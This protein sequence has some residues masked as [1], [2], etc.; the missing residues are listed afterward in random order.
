MPKDKLA[1]WFE[2]YAAALELNVWPSTTLKSSSWDD[3]KRQWTVTL[4]STQDGE[5]RDRKP[6]PSR[7]NFNKSD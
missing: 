3:S 5:K 6:C 1:D 2:Y 7:S 4:V